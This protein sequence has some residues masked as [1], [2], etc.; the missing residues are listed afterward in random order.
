VNPQKNWEM[1]CCCCCSAGAA[2]FTHDFFAREA[3]IR[4]KRMGLCRSIKNEGTRI[5]ERLAEEIVHDT[6]ERAISRKGRERERER[7]KKRRWISL[8]MQ[9]TERSIRTDRRGTPVGA[10]KRATSTA[11]GR[12]GK[13]GDELDGIAAGGGGWIPGSGWTAAVVRRKKAAG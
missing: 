7:E 4:N 1:S 8:P 11:A 12:D 6:T 9:R 2:S 10:V 13:G 5:W 3:L